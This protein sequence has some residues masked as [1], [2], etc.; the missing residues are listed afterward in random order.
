MKSLF[1]AKLFTPKQLTFIRKPIARV[2]L[3]KTCLQVHYDPPF[4]H[5]SRKRVE[6]AF[7]AQKK[8]KKKRRKEEKIG[9]PF[10]RLTRALLRGIISILINSGRGAR[11]NGAFP[12]RLRSKNAAERWSRSLNLKSAVCVSKSTPAAWNVLF[13]RKLSW[14]SYDDYASVRV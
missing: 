11:N 5:P 13:R 14:E 12:R 6:I 10:A 7:L 1:I 4:P 9:S 2:F 3:R 8:K